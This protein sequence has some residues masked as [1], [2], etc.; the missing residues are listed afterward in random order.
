MRLAQHWL[1]ST[2]DTCVLLLTV[3]GA[4]APALGAAFFVA[5]FFAGAFAL[6]AAFFGA[7]AFAMFSF[8]N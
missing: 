5:G 8:G 1:V 3:T 4:A 2:I 7:A 6:G